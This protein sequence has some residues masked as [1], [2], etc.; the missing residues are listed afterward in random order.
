MIR[1]KNVEWASVYDCTGGF[2]T[3]RASQAPHNVQFV[4]GDFVHLGHSHQG[5]VTPDNANN[6]AIDVQVRG[7]CGSATMACHDDNFCVYSASP[8]SC[9]GGDR[10]FCHV[11]GSN[12]GYVK[13]N[14][15]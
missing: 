14:L 11:E 13:I 6:Q 1:K 7:R 10:S 8:W 15:M 9:V 4:I 5:N 2:A 3:T 12:M